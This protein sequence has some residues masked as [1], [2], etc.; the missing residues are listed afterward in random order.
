MR[1]RTPKNMCHLAPI[2]N[3]E[4]IWPA[5]KTCWKWCVPNYYLVSMQSLNL[6]M[7]TNILHFFCLFVEVSFSKSAKMYLHVENSGILVPNRETATD[8]SKN[9]WRTPRPS[10]HVTAMLLT[11]TNDIYHHC[12]TLPVRHLVPVSPTPLSSFHNS[13]HSNI[14]GDNL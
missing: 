12:A 8:L 13:T 14:R 9:Y 3:F 11:L 5:K 10:H 1:Q 4:Y 6:K 7:Y 2:R